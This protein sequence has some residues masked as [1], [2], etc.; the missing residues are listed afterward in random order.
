MQE[1]FAGRAFTQEINSLDMIV[2]KDDPTLGFDLRLHV[3]KEMISRVK[4]EFP[5]CDTCP[6]LTFDENVD[7]ARDRLALRIRCS[8]AS[9]ANQIPFK[10]FTCPDGVTFTNEGDAF[11]EAIYKE[12]ENDLDYRHAVKAVSYD[13]PKTSSDIW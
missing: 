7:Y 2:N 3:M 5:A 10:V 11:N 8:A 6:K 9:P 13:T 1:R 4:E 12:K